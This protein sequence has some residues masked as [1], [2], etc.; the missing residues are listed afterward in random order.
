MNYRSY[1]GSR[2]CVE[3][4]KEFVAYHH[5][6]KY[7]STTCREEV[8][9]RRSREVVR[10]NSSRRLSIRFSVLAR[11]GFRCQYC[12][13]TPEDNVKLEVDHIFP[14]I[15][16]GSDDM[17]NLITACQECNLGKKDYILVNMANLPV[18]Y[19]L[20]CGKEDSLEVKSLV[21]LIS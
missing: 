15:F 13:R 12:G 9:R 18:N 16:G 10:R 11:D 7:C 17:N 2:L 1:S 6:R 4:G 8:N 19:S 20:L 21:K 14:R 3:C 5:N